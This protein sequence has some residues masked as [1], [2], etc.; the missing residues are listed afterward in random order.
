MPIPHE[1]Y[2]KQILPIPYNIPVSTAKD[3]D[4]GKSEYIP[5]S[6]RNDGGIEAPTYMTHNDLHSMN[7]IIL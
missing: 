4:M 3:V 7:V 2:I 5:L 1:I 6:Q